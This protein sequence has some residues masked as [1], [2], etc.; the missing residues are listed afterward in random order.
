MSPEQARSEPAS[1]QSDVFALGLMIYEMLTGEKAIRG[2]NLLAVLRQIDTLDA[3]RYAE[4]MPEPLDT[5][6]RR[7]LATDARKRDITMSEIA[8]LLNW[9][10]YSIAT[11]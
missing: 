6:L 9:R 7:S 2:T 11:A 4:G 8:E 5:I 1:S 10:D 3:N